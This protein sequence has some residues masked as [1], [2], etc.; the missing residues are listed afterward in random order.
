ML[1]KQLIEKLHLEVLSSEDTLDR[2][3][4]RGYASDLLSDVLAYARKGD[5]WVTLQVHENIVAVAAMNELSA[6]VVINGRKP[7]KDTVEK[8]N[9]ERIPILGTSLPSF[10]L[11]GR[12]YTMGIPGKQDNAAGV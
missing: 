4:T 8:A 1:L 2:E 9:R 3:I 5:L 10:E 12:L 11:I 6:I 7:N